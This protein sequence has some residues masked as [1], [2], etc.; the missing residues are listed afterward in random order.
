MSISREDVAT[1]DDVKPR[2]GSM[3]Q[4]RVR[5]MIVLVAC[6][7]AILWA[8]RHWVENADP[9]LVEARS[10]LRNAI[11]DLKSG[12]PADRIGAINFLARLLPKDNMVAILPLTT[13]LDHPDTAV[14][15]AAAEALGSISAAAVAAG[16][17]TEAVRTATAV[18]LRCMKDPETNIRFAAARSLQKIAGVRPA[19]GSASPVDREAIRS[20][21]LELYNDRDP[22]LRSIA[23]RALCSFTAGPPEA[24][25]AGLKDESA[26]VRLAT[27][28]L[29]VHHSRGLD[30]WIPRLIALAE[31][32]P[33]PNVREECL[34]VLHPPFFKPPA[35]T[36]AV[37]PAVLAGLKTDVVRIRGTL[38]RFLAQLGPEGR[39]AIPELLQLVKAPLAPKLDRLQHLEVWE[40]A[41]PG[42]EASLTLGA[43]APAT[44]EAPQVI[45][46]LT[47]V[48][49]SG[50]LMRR[51]R[52][53]Y[54]LGLFGPAAVEALPVLITIVND[55][56]SI[57]QI[58]ELM[59]TARSTGRD[60][61][62]S[63][64]VHGEA[65]AARALG[66]I[67]PGT[68]FADQAIEAL[69]TVL[70]SEAVFSRAAAVE[71]LGQFGPKAASALPRIRE[72]RNDRDKSVSIAVTRALPLIER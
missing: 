38:L 50:P 66:K 36:A 12:K 49:R 19:I 72:L 31:L 20:A 5:A 42:S 62:E 41:D 18:L 39:A 13:A 34:H 51:T 15:V 37:I 48:A 7:A 45:A 64:Y 30:S 16:S 17:M 59:Q 43:I 44:P 22:R 11:S 65:E 9:D 68:P 28:Q 52:T 3:L 14:R 70:N 55:P 60:P 25:A 23:L 69:R 27:I 47:E 40:D 67:A 2:K 63:Q 46:A 35:V 8:W 33:D 21:T 71:A 4:A 32:D 61:P 58:R 29:L 53:V 6:C 10:S 57:K 24:L 26:E 56:N 54:A 1:A